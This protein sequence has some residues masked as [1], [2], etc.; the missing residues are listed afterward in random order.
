VDHGLY[1]GSAPHLPWKK[2]VRWILDRTK[3]SSK[4]HNPGRA[5]KVSLAGN[6]GI[7]GAKEER[8]TSPKE[9]GTADAVTIGSSVD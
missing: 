8:H 3:A 9:G 5:N 4:D 2:L 1:W 6:G 7:D